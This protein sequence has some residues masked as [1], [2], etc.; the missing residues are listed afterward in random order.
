MLREIPIDSCCI[1]KDLG[2]EGI[3]KI[4]LLGAFTFSTCCVKVCRIG[5]AVD[6]EEV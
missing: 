1:M 3:W 6:V 5:V 2:L 4:Y